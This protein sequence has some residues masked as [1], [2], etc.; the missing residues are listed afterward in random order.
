MYEIDFTQKQHVLIFCS[1][2]SVQDWLVLSSLGKVSLRL[3]KSFK[4]WISTESE[5][6]QLKATRSARCDIW[7]SH[8][9][10]APSTTKQVPGN[11]LIGQLLWK[12]DRPRDDGTLQRVFLWTGPHIHSDP[13]I[14]SDRWQHS[15]FLR[16]FIVLSKVGIIELETVASPQVINVFYIF[17]CERISS[18][19]DFLLEVEPKLGAQILQRPGKTWIKTFNLFSVFM[20]NIWCTFVLSK[21]DKFEKKMN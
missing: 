17:L 19:K 10:C 8:S 5:D 20:Q 14:K 18:S 2:Q 1:F 9:Q 7:Y 11:F 16:C 4:V 12:N 6:K 21:A 13:S 3:N 15:Q